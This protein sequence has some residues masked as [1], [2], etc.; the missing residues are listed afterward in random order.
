MIDSEV[1][2]EEPTDDVEAEQEVPEAAEELTSP[3]SDDSTLTEDESSDEEGEEIS[4]EETEAEESTEEVEETFSYKLGGEYDD[5]EVVIKIIKKPGDVSTEDL[6]LGYLRNKDY[7]VKNSERARAEE[8]AQ[9]ALE[10]AV[11][12]SKAFENEL[13]FRKERLDTPEMLELKEYDRDAYDEEKKRIEVGEMELAKFNDKIKQ[14]EDKRFSEQSKIVHKKISDAMPE[15]IDQDTKTND[16]KEMTELLNH[17]EV[18]P[19]IQAG[20]YNHIALPILKL[21]V[22]SW[23]AEK[24]IQEKAKSKPPK[25]SKSSSKSKSSK[26]VVK[27]DHELFFG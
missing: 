14:E 27:E 16:L 5:D 12:Q 18:E 13:L 17:F 6:K 4:E 21:A 2:Y 11:E 23:K 7:T 9:A 19:E 20:F 26:P 3:P 8:A 1:F 25:S 15:W 22:K 24:S 10:K